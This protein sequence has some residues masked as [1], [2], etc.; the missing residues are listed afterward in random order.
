[1]VGNE[2][3]DGARG[4]AMQDVVGH[5][6]T[7]FYFKYNEKLDDSFEHELGMISSIASCLF[8]ELDEL[9]NALATFSFI[10]FQ[11]FMSTFYF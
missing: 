3:G 8:T 10:L 7:S 5:D 11:K 9:P 4:R 6:R 1:M 2:V